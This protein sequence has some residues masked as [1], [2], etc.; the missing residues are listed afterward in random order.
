MNEIVLRASTTRSFIPSAV[1]RWRTDFGISHIEFQRPD[2][3]TLGARADGHGVAERPASFN[4][5]Q[6]NII[7][8]TFDG[9][10][11]AHDWV[12]KNRLGFEYDFKGIFG[13]AFGKAD[14]HD[15]GARDCSCLV[16][17]GAEE[18]AKNF[19]LNRDLRIWQATPRDIL[20]SPRVAILQAEKKML[21]EQRFVM[22]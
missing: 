2:G 19:L 8:A 9:I 17:E 1:I 7:L 13:I 6:E 4:R 16:L 14:W 22:R 5:D 11:R 15:S 10:E 20:A 18:G 12:L 21:R 3:S